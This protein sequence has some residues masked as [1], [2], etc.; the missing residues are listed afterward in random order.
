MAQE[1]SKYAAV[2][3]PIVYWCALVAAIPSC[4]HRV[5]DATVSH[6]AGGHLP[7]AGEW[8][9]R[10][11]LPVANL[12]SLYFSQDAAAWRRFLAPQVEYSKRVASSIGSRFELPS[13][14]SLVQYNESQLALQCR[15]QEFHHSKGK[16]GPYGVAFRSERTSCKE[17]MS[18]SGGSGKS[19]LR[20]VSGWQSFVSFLLVWSDLDVATL[21]NVAGMPLYFVQMTTDATTQFDGVSGNSI[22]FMNHDITHALKALRANFSPNMG[23]KI[24][25]IYDA[26]SGITEEEALAGVPPDMRNRSCF[27]QTDRWNRDVLNFI[28]S[29]DKFNSEE[30]RY[31]AEALWFV[32]HHEVEFNYPGSFEQLGRFSP[33]G[34]YRKSCFH[35]FIARA[36]NSFESFL[37]PGSE[38]KRQDLPAYWGGGESGEGLN[39]ARESLF[40]STKWT[41]DETRALRGRAAEIVVKEIRKSPAN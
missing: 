28:R 7:D 41:E 5:F 18:D 39:I 34:D 40:P 6:D 30:D 32:F 36:R 16:D 35:H 33:E 17:F 29:T 27:A 19:F 4:R 2:C 3:F 10:P 11:E 25:E 1:K 15:I 14:Y 20:I 31:A 38:A 37:L 8:G 13:D 26:K 23:S 21:N 9:K 12:S 22:A 24:S